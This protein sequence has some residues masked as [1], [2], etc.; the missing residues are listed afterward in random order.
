MESSLKDFFKHPCTIHRSEEPQNF[1]R[2]F[3]GEEEEEGK[4]KNKTGTGGKFYDLTPQIAQA[5]ICLNKAANNFIQTRSLISQ[6]Y[7]QK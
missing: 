2:K 4:Q 7:T 3:Q 5:A 1:H 6:P